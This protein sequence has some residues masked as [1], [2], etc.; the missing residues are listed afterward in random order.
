MELGQSK[1]TQKDETIEVYKVLSIVCAYAY[2]RYSNPTYN[3]HAKLLVT[4]D[5]KTSSLMGGGSGMMKD[6]SE[7]LGTKSSV[8]NEAEILKTHDLMEN[9]VNSMNLNIEY[10]QGGLIH[11]IELYENIPFKVHIISQPDTLLKPVKF[12]VEKV[13]VNKIKITSK[14]TD[15]SFIINYGVR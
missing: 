9:V 7:L 14:K 8:D 5:D 12:D 11:S 4:D 3:I 1:K 2:V 6:F 13:A 15:S 10:S